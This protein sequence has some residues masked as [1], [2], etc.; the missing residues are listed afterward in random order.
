LTVGYTEGSTT[1][2]EYSHPFSYNGVI[3]QA[4]VDVSGESFQD[5]EAES[6]AAMMRQ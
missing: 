1:S 6:A 5:L 4:L 3:Y 2:T